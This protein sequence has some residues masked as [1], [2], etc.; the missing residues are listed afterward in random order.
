MNKNN[1]F[2]KISILANYYKISLLYTILSTIFIS[3]IIFKIGIY[4]FFY[5]LP[6]IYL[7]DLTIFKISKNFIKNNFLKKIFTNLIYRKIIIILTLLFSYFI[8]EFIVKFVYESYFLNSITFILYISLFLTIIYQLIYII[9]HYII[10]F[11][12][13]FYFFTIFNSILLLLLNIYSSILFGIIIFILYLLISI[14]TFE[15]FLNEKFYLNIKLLFV[16]IV[17]LISAIISYFPAINTKI[18]EETGLLEKKFF[19]FNFSNR[20]IIKSDYKFTGEIIFYAKLNKPG[21]FKAIVYPDYSKKNGFYSSGKIKLPYPQYIKNKIWENNSY[22]KGKNFRIQDNSIIFNINLNKDFVIGKNEIFKII[23]YENWIDSPFT[24]IYESDSLSLDQTLPYDISFKTLDKK[25]FKYYT[26]IEIND[27]EVED[28]INNYAKNLHSNQAKIEF[29]YRMFK[30]NYYYSLNPEGGDGFKGIKKFLLT[31]KKGYCSHFAYSYCMILRYLKIPCRIVGGFKV[32]N[33]NKIFD[34]YKVYDYNAHSWVEVYTDRYGWF[35]IDPTSDRLAPGETFNTPAKN[36]DKENIY[37]ESLLKNFNKLKKR[38]SKTFSNINKNKTDNLNNL[39]N[40]NNL[41]TLFTIIIILIFLLTLIYLFR[42]YILF[43]ILNQASSNKL[44]KL[45]FNYFYKSLAKIVS[46]NQLKPIE[47]I[48]NIMNNRGLNLEKFKE[49]YIDFFFSYNKNRVLSRIGF[50]QFIN[51]YYY[52]LKNLLSS[53]LLF[54]K[55]S[56]L[57]GK[58]NL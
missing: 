10:K 39:K 5:I 53:K 43:F 16:F 44:K 49:D 52:L 25:L 50:K 56:Y 35:P 30:L 19:K 20:L 26:Y 33:S 28:F 11:K 37:L 14:L 32:M 40:K 58:H 55:A 51:C 6:V 9:N 47:E 54:W 2:K 8:L 41:N 31:Y 27:K 57:K 13:L 48:S 18:K 17:F 3:G 15:L 1:I 4:N 42:F 46:K 36:S 12:T 24:N 23:P 45:I 22:I 29:F 21:L 7:L 34:F 38:S